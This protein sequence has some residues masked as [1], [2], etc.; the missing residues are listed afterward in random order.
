MPSPK[1][2]TMT[3]D[4]RVD[5]SIVG[6]VSRIQTTMELS[7]DQK[8]ENSARNS[9][10]Q[11]QKNAIM[12]LIDAGE[13]KT[14]P[15]I[16]QLDPMELMPK[17]EPCGITA[18][19]LFSGGGGLDLGFELAGF[20]H[21]SS[22]DYSISLT[23]PIRVN[24]P[25]WKLFSGEEGDVTKVNWKSISSHPDVIHG[26]PPCQPY[27]RSGRQRGNEDERDMVPEFTRAIIELM[28]K[29]FVM[30]NVKGILDKGFENHM[31]EEFFDRLSSNQ[32]Q[33]K[34]NNK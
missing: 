14:P 29:A 34:P 21:H 7:D 32:Y 23:E 9:R 12:A 25:H 3:V 5:P 22:Y 13:G 19:S 26:G 31:K 16:D 10:S 11:R 2:D 1:G 30:E 6:E 28:P 8:K 27:S 17:L 24:R 33:N 4:R 20:E 15:K 18:L